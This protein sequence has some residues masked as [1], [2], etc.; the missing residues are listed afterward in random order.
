MLKNF[1]AILRQ[2]FDF[3]NNSAVRTAGLEAVQALINESGK[4]IAPCS[5]RWLS[6]DRSVNRLKSCFKSVVISLQRESQERSDARA[7][8]LVSMTCEFRFI[9]TM[10]LLCDTSLMFL[11]CRNVSRL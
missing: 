2:L 7:L 1:H 3:F 6:V 9:A 8:G 4:L 5:T 11:I 10:L